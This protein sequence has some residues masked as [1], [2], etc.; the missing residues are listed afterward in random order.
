MRNLKPIIRRSPP[1]ITYG[2]Y[3]LVWPHSIF[4]VED[5]RVHIRDTI[6]ERMWDMGDIPHEAFTSQGVFHIRTIGW[7]FPANKRRSTWLKS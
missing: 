6:K 4:V 5:I 2:N 7:D 1:Q 3:E